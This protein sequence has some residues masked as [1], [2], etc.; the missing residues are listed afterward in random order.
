M[1]PKVDEEG[2]EAGGDACASNCWVGNSDG[3][4]VAEDGVTGVASTE[5]IGVDG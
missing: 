1:N 3:S 4:K 2:G 5:A